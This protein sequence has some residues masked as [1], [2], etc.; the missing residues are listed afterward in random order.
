MWVVPRKKKQGREI[1]CYD[2]VQGTLGMGFASRE[3]GM[4]KR[5]RDVSGGE[6]AL[7]TFSLTLGL[8]I[9]YFILF[10]TSSSSLSIVRRGRLL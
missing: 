6:T 10:P 9:F 7:V 4:D 8:V 3:G 1:A 2:T 5:L